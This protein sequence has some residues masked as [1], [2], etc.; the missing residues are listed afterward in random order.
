MI[1]RHVLPLGGA[2][3]RHAP[4][5]RP[6][7]AHAHTIPLMPTSITLLITARSSFCARLF[8]QTKKLF[9]RNF[10]PS[11]WRGSIFLLKNA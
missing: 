2:K 4:A 10:A 1:N 5:R 8:R 7:T 11:G 9:F 6:K 3:G